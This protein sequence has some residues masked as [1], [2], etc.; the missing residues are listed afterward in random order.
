MNQLQQ[1]IDLSENIDQ[2]ASDARD[3]ECHETKVLLDL[4]WYFAEK[5][6]RE[7]D[8]GRCSANCTGKGYCSVCDHFNKLRNKAESIKGRL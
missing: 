5:A 7:E 8:G 6:V 2:L 3:C 1:L 4:A